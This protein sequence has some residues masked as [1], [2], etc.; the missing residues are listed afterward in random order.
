MVDKLGARSVRVDTTPVASTATAGTSRKSASAARAPADVSSAGALRT[1]EVLKQ[2]EPLPTVLPRARAAKASAVADALPSKADA[3]YDYVF[4]GA[5]TAAAVAAARMAEAGLKVL[6]L[7]AGGDAKVANPSAVEPLESQIPAAHGI[8]SESK[9]LAVGGTSY[10]VQHRSDDA[11]NAQD[12]NYDPAT[13]GVLYP[14]GEG[15]GGSSRMNAMIYVRPDREDFNI[16]AE[17]TGDARWK[18][19]NVEKLLQRIEKVEYRPE[20]KAIH[21]LGKALRLKK[22]QNPHGLGFDGWLHL[23]RPVPLSLAGDKQ[24][25]KMVW[26]TT[27]FSMSNLGSIGDRLTRMANLFDPNDSKVMGTEGMTLTPLAVTSDGRRTGARARLM[28]ARAEHPDKIEIRD[29]AQ[30]EKVLLDDNNEAR[31]VRYTDKAGKVHDIGARQGVIIAAGAFESP[32]VL[33][34]SGVGTAAELAPLGITPK[35]ELPGTGEGLSDRYEYG[36]VFQLKEPLE[37]LTALTPPLA[38]VSQLAAQGVTKVEDI[39]AAAASS[40]AL[41]EWLDGKKTAL[42][43]NGVIAAFQ[44]KSTPDLKEPDL[45]MFL[46]PGDFHGYHD[47]YAKGAT[48]DPRLMTLVMLHENKSDAK[49]S[50]KLDP[51]NPRGKP[52]IDFTYHEEESTKVDDRLPLANAVLRFARPLLAAYGDIVEREVL[53]GP[54]LKSL[55]QVAEK[56]GR[57]TWG[58]HANHSAR[59]GN[60]TDSM[61]VVGGDLGVLGTRGLYVADASVLHNP[62][63]FIVSSV[64]V[65]GEQ[66]ADIAIEKAKAAPAKTGVRDVQSAQLL[67]GRQ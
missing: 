7:E 15:V 13:K 44:A 24:L 67:R 23:N 34:R 46:V 53:P 8:A 17:A 65:V 22:L 37:T 45:Y 41:R 26:E 12:P 52:K 4:V 30:V 10:K 63:P 42:S 55:E 57:G 47:G 28:E 27:K 59:I 20:L 33:K 54:E 31:G 39:E 49:G 29:G 61:T 25:L 1:G 9:N 19:D 5:G 6:L 64:M 38:L 3:K 66:M 60:P 14:R 51:A 43:T 18:W 11:K 36:Y 2:G 35:V 32:A 48:A 58:H 21:D 62:G 16:I 56:I 50:V 40:P